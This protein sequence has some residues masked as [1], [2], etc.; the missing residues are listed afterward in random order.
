M[1]GLFG[2]NVETTD[3]SIL[4]LNGFYP[5]IETQ[6]NFDVQLYSRTVSYTIVGTDALMVWTPAPL[7]LPTA[8]ANGSQE[9]I[10][11]ANTQEANIVAES[12][13]S[14]DLLTAVTG[15][16]L[17]DRPARF[18]DVLDAMGAV[19]DSLDA[20]LAA[21]EAATSVDEINNIVNPPTGIINIGRGQFGGPLDLNASNYVSFNS[22][23]MLQSETELYAPATSSVVPYQGFP[24]DDFNSSGAIFA[25][26]DY[27][28]QI[29][30]TAT[31]SVIAEFEVPLSLDGSNEDIAF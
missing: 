14:T 27:L 28:I 24:P 21:I 5:V 3:I 20:N 13:L 22:V 16:E 25:T 26:G 4:N 10:A 23:S 8:I 1:A 17:I 11:K 18:Q 2:I 19:S 30:E 31:G 6:P 12:Q 9:E 15:Q 29:R 7:P